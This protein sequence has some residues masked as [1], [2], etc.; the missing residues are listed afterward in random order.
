VN[1]LS[2]AITIFPDHGSGVWVGTS[3]TGGASADTSVA[4][5]PGA[6]GAAGSGA[7]AGTFNGGATGRGSMGNR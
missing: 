3:E 1:Q 5:S 7:A 4:G 6:G 2:E